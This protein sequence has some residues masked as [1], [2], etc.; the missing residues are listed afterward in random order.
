M[1]RIVYNWWAWR[2]SNPH[3]SSYLFTCL[4]DREDTCPM[5]SCFNCDEPTTNPKFCSRSCAAKTNNTLI[6]KR[7]AKSNNCIRCGCQLKS[8]RTICDDCTAPDMTLEE[9]LY[10]KHHPSSAAALVRSRARAATKHLDKV[11][12]HC[13]YSKHVEVCHIKAVSTFTLDTKLSVINDLSNLILLCPNCH[14]EFD[15]S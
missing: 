3:V 7:I 1:F 6:P 12:S 11:C 15:H 14:W 2:D 10:K 13:G 5:V 8:G 4:E 9:A